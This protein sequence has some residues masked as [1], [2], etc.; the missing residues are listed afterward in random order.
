MQWGWLK[1]MVIRETNMCLW[2]SR[3]LATRR[4]S[5]SLP[6]KD[7]LR[8]LAKAGKEAE[9][10]DTNYLEY[11][12]NKHLLE[13]VILI[14]EPNCASR[15]GDLKVIADER[16]ARDARNNLP[17]FSGHN[18]PPARNRARKLHTGCR[19]DQVL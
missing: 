13:S 14:R 3:Q 16:C 9:R 11:A 6:P 7:L 17:C 4:L 5:L 15:S 19:G 8:A 10:S 12:A 2:E 18:S 1:Q